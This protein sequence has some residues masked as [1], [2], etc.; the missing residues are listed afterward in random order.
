MLESGTRSKPRKQARTEKAKSEANSRT[1][2]DDGT[3]KAKSEANSR[4]T[5]DDGTEKAK[6][7]ANSRTTDDDGGT[8]YATR[9]DDGQ[10]RR[11]FKSDEQQDGSRSALTKLTHE[12]RQSP[13]EEG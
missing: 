7:E 11:R 3:E 2:D 6:S 8:G 5:D 9:R 10:I 4:T 13:H 1:T 12:A